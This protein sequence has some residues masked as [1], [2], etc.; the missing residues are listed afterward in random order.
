MTQGEIEALTVTMEQA[1]SRLEI[2]L[3]KDIVRRIKANSDITSSAEYQI[4]RLR[5]LGLADDYIK[6]KIQIYLKA[7]EK[8]ISRLYS[9]VIENEYE[10]FASVYSDMDITFTP[11]GEHIALQT[12]VQAVRKQTEDTFTNISQTLGFS[13]SQGG[14]SGFVSISEYYQRSIDNAIL[15]IAS[16]AFDYNTALNKVVKEMTRSGLRTVDYASGRKYRIESASRTAMMTGFSQVTR[17]MNE[18]TAHD[19]GTEDYETSYHIGARPAHQL[20]QGRVYS[21]QE[22]VDI[23][24]LGSVTGL[25][26]ANCYHWY[27]PFI[28]GISVR[29]YTDDQLNRMIADENRP[30][31][32]NGKEYTTYEALQ[33]QRSMELLMRKQRQDITLL[34]DGEG[35]DLDILAAQTRYRSTM[36]EYAEFSESMRL[37]QQRERIYMDGLGKL[38]SQ[39]SIQVARKADRLYNKGSTEANVKVYIQ[40]EKLRRELKSDDTPKSIEYGK[41]GKHIKTHN[42][43]MPGRSYLIITE[44]EAQELVNRYAGTGWIQRDGKGNWTHKEIITSD[45]TIGVVVN[46]VTGEETETRKFVIHYSKNGVHIVPSREEK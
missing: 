38:V 21:Y 23:C 9:E 34:S 13:I 5:Q 14:K 16:G 22:L 31:Q 32:Y 15:G 30:K 10:K 29:T 41:Q 44:S 6:Q 8:E 11:F 46:P 4:N 42:N 3:M 17:Y 40:D 19:L 26:G 37:P 28:R 36:Q 24:G 12:M 27:T 39:K 7:S 45:K 18:Q 43:Y 2:D 33:K 35:N 20:W 25:C 1:A